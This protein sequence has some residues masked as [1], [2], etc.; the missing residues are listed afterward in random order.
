MKPTRDGLSEAGMSLLELMISVA[1]ISIVLLSVIYAMTGAVQAQRN[2]RLQDRALADLE[3][4]REQ[5][6][7]VPYD[8]VRD[9][10]PDGSQVP[11][12]NNV[13]GEVITITYPGSDP[14]ADPLPINITIR[15]RNINNAVITRT[16]QLLKKK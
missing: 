7:A 12:F 10:F 13:P 6:L 4:V 9:V 11:A 2:A 1:I 3:T 8:S 15:W 16:L 5:V 14:N